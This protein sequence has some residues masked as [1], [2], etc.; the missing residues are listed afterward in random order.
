M[1]TKKCSFK[2]D[3]AESVIVWLIAICLISSLCSCG[4][5]VKGNCSGNKTMAFYGGHSRSAFNK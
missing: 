3:A 2:L 4:I 5:V 1:K